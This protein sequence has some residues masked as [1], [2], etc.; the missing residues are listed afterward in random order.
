MLN[1]KDRFRQK[2]VE[3]EERIAEVFRFENKLAP[4]TIIDANYWVFG[5][6]PELIPDDYFDDDPKIM[7]DIQTEKIIRH[8]DSFPEDSY[9]GFL[10]P[11]FGTGVL[12]S[13]FGVDVVF[14]K[15][16]DPAVAISTVK[17]VIELDALK[18][19]DYEKSGLMPRVLK[20]LRYFKE[21]CDLPIGVTDCQGPLTTA[22]SIIGYDNFVYWMVD[23]PDKIHAL[24]DLVTESLIGW[25]KYQKDIIGV[26]RESAPYIIGLKMAEGSGGV[27]IADDDC[28]MMGPELYAEFVKPY[29]EKVLA[30][31]GGGGIHYCGRATQHIENYMNTAGLTCLHNL[32]Q[33]DYES[34]TQMAKAA[35][36]KGIVFYIC[37]YVPG[38]D[39]LDGYYDDLFSG[40]GQ[41]GLIVSSYIA[42]SIALIK[43]KYELKNREAHALAKRVDEMIRQ[44]RKLYSI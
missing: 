10:M 38:D 17:D 15:K 37:D 42:P 32:H 24:M 27:W 2:D 4:Y 41:T 36:D 43:G 30:A 9:I 13:A 22:L 19:P 5:D 29:N 25:V 35:K 12:A 31:F 34:V 33:D 20:Q 39:R 3:S 18:T 21:N 14:Q 16:M 23:H 26:S 6:I 28:C 8:Y 11:W 1:L 7:T 44:K 40:I